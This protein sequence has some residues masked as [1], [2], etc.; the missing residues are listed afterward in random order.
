[1][2]IFHSLSLKICLAAQPTGECS[3]KEVTYFSHKH[4]NWDL[5]D[6]SLCSHLYVVPFL[7]PPVLSASILH[8]HQLMSAS[9]FHCPQHPIQRWLRNYLI[10]IDAI[11]R[12]VGPVV[13]LSPF[14]KLHEKDTPCWEL[15]V[16]PGDLK[17]EQMGWVKQQSG[18]ARTIS[19][20]QP[21]KG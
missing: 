4:K 1:M 17:Q 5:S 14:H 3:P 18:K 12:H 2:I 10:D 20:T 11:P 7:S 13:H 16:D 15:P 21:R 9:V 19:L 6:W 8:Q